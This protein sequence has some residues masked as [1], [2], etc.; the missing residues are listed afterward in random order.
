VALS[1]YA[2]SWLTLLQFDVDYDENVLYFIGFSSITGYNFVKYFGL[3]KFHH[4][5]LT[6]KLK[7]IQIFSL[8]CFMALCY[9]AFKLKVQTLG[10]VGLFGAVT[11]LYAI[12]LVPKKIFVDKQKN[13]RTIGGLKIY[14]IATVWTGV[15]VF[16]PLINNYYAINDDVFITAFQR[17]LLVIVLMLPFEIRDLSYDSL[18]L[19]TIPQRIGVR[20]TKILGYI[21]LFVFL[22]MEFFKDEMNTASLFIH[23]IITLIVLLLLAFTNINQKKYYSAFWVESLPIWWLLLLLLFR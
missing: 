20:R 16:L 6:N 14:V 7:A 1:I 13:L 3:A 23:I 5:S 18:R 22:C 8:L 10:Y 21:L 17:F 2:L 12:P 15:T 9:F 4:R 11:F 19:S